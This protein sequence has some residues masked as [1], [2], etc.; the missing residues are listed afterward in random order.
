MNIISVIVCSRKASKKT[1][2]LD[3]IAQTIGCDYEYIKI[4]NSENKYSITQAYNKGVNNAKGD[5]LV[6]IHEDVF[7]LTEN[8]G[9][10]LLE[11]FRK[12]DS[13]GLIGVAGTKALLNKPGSWASAGKEYHCGQVVHDLKHKDGQ[14]LTMFSYDK[15]DTKVVAVDGLFFTVRGTLFERIRFDEQTFR[16]FHF[17]DLDICMQVSATHDIIVTYDIL[18]KHLSAG[19]FDAVWKQNAELFINKYKDRLPVFITE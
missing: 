11:K 4:D 14:F 6:F 1:A 7:F 12:N 2:H 9:T 8:W 16:H 3:H 15:T 13:T 19:T 5:I 10:V 17:Y 18:L